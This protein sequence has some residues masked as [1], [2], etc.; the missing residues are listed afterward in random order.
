MAPSQEEASIYRI[1]SVQSA[2]AYV[3]LQNV[4]LK[5]PE[6]HIAHV[7][8]SFCTTLQYCVKKVII[9]S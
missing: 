5:H 3:T 4:K 7:L 8:Q 1:L 9:E 6:E 2:T